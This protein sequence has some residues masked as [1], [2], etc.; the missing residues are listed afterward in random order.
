MLLYGLLA[1]TVLTW[2]PSTAAYDLYI[3]DR[4]TFDGTHSDYAQQFY[5]RYRAGD[6]LDRITGSVPGEVHQLLSKYQLEFAKLN[7]F[8]QR[9][10]LWDA[11]YAKAGD[12]GYTKIYV[13]CGLRMSEMAISLNGY[14][15]QG[16]TEQKCS[17]PNGLAFHQSLYC[18]G[19]QMG[20][21]S[22]CATTDGTAPVHAPMWSDG[23]TEETVPENELFKHEWTEWNDTSIKYVIYAIH[24]VGDKNS[25]GKCSKPSMT[26]PC[27]VYDQSSDWCSPARGNLVQQW[28]TAE[29]RANATSPWMYALLF[30]AIAIVVVF[31]VIGYRRVTRSA[32]QAKPASATSS[33][34]EGTENSAPLRSARESAMYTTTK[35][36]ESGNRDGTPYQGAQYDSGQSTEPSE[37]TSD[38]STF[39]VGHQSGHHSGQHNHLISDFTTG[40][41]PDLESPNDVPIMEPSPTFSSFHEKKRHNSGATDQHTLASTRKATK[42]TSSI[43]ENGYDVDYSSLGLSDERFEAFK[44]IFMGLDRSKTGAITAKQF[45]ALCFELGETL[46]EEE[47]AMAVASLENEN[48]GLIHFSTF[49]PWWVSD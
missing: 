16:C 2:L 21:V 43:M 10:V 35:D 20:N 48:T 45:E 14:Q 13:K 12:R 33:D 38:A 25:Y 22:L 39:H 42:K 17:S 44:A 19:Y 23:G 37:R 49:L 26:I 29:K 40:V 9:A 30:A 32:Q 6:K 41:N 31:T 5:Q 28:L 1:T 8:L 46:D 24:L 47:M 27:V 36:L 7:P 18:S 15:S 11:G 34:D 4:F 3:D